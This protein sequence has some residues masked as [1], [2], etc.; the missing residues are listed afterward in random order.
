MIC[1]NTEMVAAVV[2]MQ[3]L[4]T[5]DSHLATSFAPLAGSMFH[6]ANISVPGV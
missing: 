6:S 4:S 5:C 3:V 1:W 2:V